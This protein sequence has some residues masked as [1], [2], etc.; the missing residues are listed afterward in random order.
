MLGYPS[1]YFIFLVESTMT[2]LRN[3]F[4]AALVAVCLA[5][6]AFAGPAAEPKMPPDEEKASR[7]LAAGIVHGPA[8]V[9]L[10]DIATMSI[11]AGM[12]FVPEKQAVAVLQSMGNPAGDTVVGVVAPEDNAAGWFMV[13]DYDDSGYIKDADGD[14]FNADEILEGM[15]EGLKQDNEERTKRNLPAMEVVGWI[16]KPT[17]DKQKNQLVWSVAAR[18]L[19]ADGKPAT[20]ES[21]NAVN[22]NT[23]ML[24]RGGYISL[25]LVSSQGQIEKDKQVA[26]TLLSTLKFVPGRRYQD[27]DAKT[28][29]VAEYGLLALVGGVAAKKL[30]LIA[31]LL[32]LLKGFAKYAV[33]VALGGVA[34]VKKFFSRNKT[35]AA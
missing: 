14:H 8:D 32:V 28:D 25:N 23:F 20:A 11:P 34:A 16:Q 1:E 22:Y 17:Y 12:M 13:A 31:G 33:L 30:G 18:D 3:I 29:K 6:P 21:E 10:R 35:P 27:F 15:K 19:T 2:S 9:K 5:L 4:I 26:A 7:E 24:G